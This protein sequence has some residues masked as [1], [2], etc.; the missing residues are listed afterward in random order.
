VVWPVFPAAGAGTWFFD[1]L[2]HLTLPAVALA[3]SIVAMLVRHTRAAV[4]GVVD[5]DY[6]TFAKARGLSSRRILFRYTL[7][8]ALIPIVTISGPVLAGTIVGGVIVESTFSVS[9]VGSLLISSVQ[10]KD[11]PMIQSVALLF[12]GVLIFMNLVADL[13][14]FAVD[15]RI[16]L[17]RS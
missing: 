14:Y 6:V 11:L 13:T 12:G 5:Q 4:M 8:N 17:G 2:W 1:E 15:P 10:A 16:R 9:G 3:L 7:R